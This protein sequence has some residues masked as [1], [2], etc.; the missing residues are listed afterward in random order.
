MSSKMKAAVEKAGD[1][2]VEQVAEAVVAVTK[3]AIVS[4]TE[5]AVHAVKDVKEI[6][7]E[8]LEEIKE[9]IK[10]RLMD[11]EVAAEAAEAPV[12]P[13]PEAQINVVMCADVSVSGML[14]IRLPVTLVNGV[15]T[16]LAE[17]GAEAPAPAPAPAEEPVRPDF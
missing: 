17:L 14:E 8:G 12:T 16:E 10:D 9:D 4:A 13:E 7:K 1:Q 3:E 11:D 2:M 15:S 5:I 6:A